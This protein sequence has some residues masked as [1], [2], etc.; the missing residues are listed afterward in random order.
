MRPSSFPSAAVDWLVPTPRAR[1]LV[2]GRPS[3]PVVKHLS[4]AGHRLTL[5]D[6]TL[7][8]A[9]KL[10]QDAAASPTFVAEPQRLPFVPASFETVVIHQGLHTLDVEAMSGQLARVLTHYGHV[11]VSYI[12]RDDSVPWVRRLL[13]L[14]REVDSNAMQGGYGAESTARLTDSRYFPEVEQHDF[15]LWVPVSRVGLLGMVASRFPELEQDRLTELLD[16]VGRLYES[17]ARPP[18]PLL[19]PYKVSCWRAWVDHTELSTPI[20]LPDEGLSIP[21]WVR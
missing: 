1:V 5:V 18:E 10:A 6:P 20:E 9:R 8:G 7:E 21:L 2:L 14:L 11:A 13:G 3:A 4:G 19:L 12:V 15:R 17:S 16:E